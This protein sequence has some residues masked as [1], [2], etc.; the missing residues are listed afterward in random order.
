M[1]VTFE[2]NSSDYGN[3]FRWLFFYNRIVLRLTLLVLLSLWAGASAVNQLGW[4]T[5]ASF[6]LQS[7]FAFF[8][9][10]AIL[11]ILYFV[12]VLR[13]KKQAIRL[14]FPISLSIEVFSEGISIEGTKSTFFRWFEIKRIRNSPSAIIIQTNIGLFIIPKKYFDDV[15][16]EQDF[17][18]KINS[19]CRQSSFLNPKPNYLIG[20]LGILPLIGG[21]NGIIMVVQGLSKY[22]DTKYVIIGVAGILFTVS[23]YGFLFYQSTFGTLFNESELQMTRS[24]LNDLVKKVEFYKLQ[25]NHYPDSLQQVDD[26]QMTFMYETMHASFGSHKAVLFNYKRIGNKYILFSSGFDGIPHTKDDVYP[27]IDVSDT[28]K[29]GL[30]KE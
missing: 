7:F 4:S 9:F 28:S 24:N 1:Q 30:M 26:D 14:H 2:T 12:T 13:F 8:I 15:K 27:T 17:F 18:Y 3:Y 19:G 23:I 5:F 22:K 16:Y 6:L 29:F 20:L 10:T 11:V 25:N 21:I